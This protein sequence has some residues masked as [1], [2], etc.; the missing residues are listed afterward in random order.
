MHQRNL[1]EVYHK[2]L[3]LSKISQYRNRRY[4]QCVLRFKGPWKTWMEPQ[5]EGHENPEEGPVR[6]VGQGL[7]PQKS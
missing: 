5:V 3:L 6:S 4:T 1:Q 2:S 7:L